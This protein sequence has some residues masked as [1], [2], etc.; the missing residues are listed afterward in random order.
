MIR[1][2]LFVLMFIICVPVYGQNVTVPAEPPAVEMKLPVKSE[3]RQAVAAAV[4]SARKKGE[5]SARQALK[6]RVALLS[7]AFQQ[8]VEDLAVTQMAFAATDEPLP[9]TA[10]GKVDRANINWSELLVFLEKLLPFIL[11]LLDL[12]AVNQL[13]TMGATA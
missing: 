7:P 10:D 11:E 6:I 1:I 2:I 8:R 3:F 9:R 12:F 5:M 13:P 4:K